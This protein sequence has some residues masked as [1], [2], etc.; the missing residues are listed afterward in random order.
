MKSMNLNRKSSIIMLFTVALS[1]GFI[2]NAYIQSVQAQVPG[3]G[4]DLKGPS[5][6][7][8]IQWFNLFKGPKGDTGPQGPQGVKGDTGDTGPQGPQGVK[9]DTGDTGATGPAGQGIELSNLYVIVNTSG[10]PGI[11]P[12]YFTA[13]VIG[14]LPFPNSFPGSETGTQVQLISGNYQVTESQNRDSI[15]SPGSI[16]FSQDC[17]GI[18]QPNEIKTCT[19]TNNY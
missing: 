5:G 7:S 4:L 18:I 12:S 11:F 6:A 19:I 16:L 10:N 14:H 9:G 1:T 15:P 17:S 3:T 13:H 2:M 8:G